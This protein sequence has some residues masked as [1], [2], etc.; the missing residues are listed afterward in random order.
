MLDV[1]R[2]ITT[3][4]FSHTEWPGLGKTRATLKKNGLE[5]TVMKICFVD[6]CFMSVAFVHRL[7]RLSTC[8]AGSVSRNRELLPQQFKNK[9]AVGQ[10]MYC[11]SG[12][13]LTYVLCEKKSQKKILLLFSPAM[14]QPK[15]RK[16][17]E[18]MVAIHK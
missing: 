18:D 13:L 12:P 3:W 15:N 11:R 17:G 8:I 5:Y 1:V 2:S 16:Y 9:F 7:H 4:G 10:K 14:P 6:S